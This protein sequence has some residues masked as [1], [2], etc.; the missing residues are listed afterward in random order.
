MGEI[1][2]DKAFAENYCEK[3]RFEHPHQFMAYSTWLEVLGDVQGLR[4][5]DLGCGSGISSRMLRARGAIVTGVDISGAML[6]K[7]KG[8]NSA[9]IDFILADAALPQKYAAEPFDLVTGAF[10]L[11]YAASSE[12]LLGFANNIALN[13]KDAGRFV[14]INMSP[15]H[16]IV[17]PGDGISHS[18]RWLDEP[19]KNGSRIEV[20]LWSQDAELIC[21]LTDYH[22]SKEAYEQALSTSGL[23]LIKWHELKMHQ[24]GKA[25]PHWQEL[26]KQNML[27]VIETY[28]K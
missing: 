13:L 14:G 11:H 16:P 21:L 6:E 9:A 4:V 7:A 24:A 18:S 1:Q 26:E 17:S 23:S 25:L 27:V 2:Y 3:Y 22:W 10:L 5:L 15:E 8:D 19:F 28:K 20:K 12:M